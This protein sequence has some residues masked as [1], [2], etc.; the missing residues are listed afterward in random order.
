MAFGW[1]HRFVR[2]RVASRFDFSL[3]DR[4]QADD[5]LQAAFGKQ[6]DAA[7]GHIWALLSRPWF[8]RKWVIQELVRSRRPL[9]VVGRIPPFSWAVLAGW[10]RFVHFCPVVKCHFL[11]VCP[12]PQFLEAGTKMQGMDMVRA[13]ILTQMGARGKQ[14]LLFLIVRTLGFHC[15]DP[16]D[17]I[18]ELLGIASDR[19]RFDHID[20]NSPAEEIW[21][22][23][24]HVCVS[25]STSLKVLWSLVMFAP[26]HRRVHS[27]VPDLENMRIDGGSSMLVTMFTVQQVRNYD[28]SG[29]SVLQA[30][31]DDGPGG[32][33]LKIRGRIMDELQLIGSD[34]RSLAH[35]QIM[36]WE[37]RNGRISLEDLQ[38]DLRDRC[39]WREECMAIVHPSCTGCANCE[40]CFRDALL[41]DHVVFKKFGKYLELA[42]SRFSAQIRLEK[43]MAYAVDNHS[44]SVG[45]LKSSYSHRAF[46]WIA[47]KRRR[48]SGDPAAPKGGESD[49]C[50]W[51]PKRET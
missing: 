11:A 27:W 32:K 36:T 41:Y 25:D 19:A 15:G 30:Y 17:H 37:D 43:A 7:F 29:G 35:S 31:V 3:I 47:S 44:F 4:G 50:Q 48:C 2:V 21:R 1:L 18:F 16:R 22:R 5:M 8:T 28:T 9:M 46:S 10:M 39:Q 45:T 23:L 6:R 33:M 26:L 12:K 42:R 20:Y 51:S 34:S 24:A 49:G 40:E 14:V 13:T 38:G